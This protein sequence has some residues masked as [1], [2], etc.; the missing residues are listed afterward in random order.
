[1]KKSNKAVHKMIKISK[2]INSEYPL[3][4][5][6]FAELLDDDGYKTDAWVAHHI[7]E[8]M[9]YPLDI[10]DKALKVIIKYSK[11]DTIHGLGNRIWLENWYKKKS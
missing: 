9:N 11:E 4:I 3:R 7:L 1:M 8:N 5:Y 2:Y 10:E 6:E